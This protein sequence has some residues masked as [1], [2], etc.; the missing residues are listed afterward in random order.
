[1]VTISMKCTKK[2]VATLMSLL[3]GF[4]KDDVSEP[5]IVALCKAPL[6]GEGA[7]RTVKLHEPLPL[8]EAVRITKEHLKLG[9][10]RLARAGNVHHRLIM[11]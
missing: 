4:E 8:D 7:G 1:M 3:R 6:P 9:H 5:S 2:G 10:V 11:M